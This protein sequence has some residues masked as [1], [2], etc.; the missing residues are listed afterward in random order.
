MPEFYMTLAQ[1]I[2]KMPEFFI[3]IAQKI[4]FFSNFRGA[5]EARATGRRVN[6]FYYPTRPV[7]KRG[8]IFDPTR[9]YTRCP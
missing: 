4:F 8:Q 6:N 7:A 1:K 2:N 9:G 3:I 5:R